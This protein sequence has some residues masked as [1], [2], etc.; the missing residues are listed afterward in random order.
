MMRR[1]IQPW[2]STRKLGG[3]WIIASSVTGRE[4]GRENGKEGRGIIAIVHCLG[5]RTSSLFL[6]V[7]LLLSLFSF[8]I[9]LYLYFFYTLMQ[10]YGF[11]ITHST[12]HAPVLVAP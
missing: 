5:H 7:F 9:F 4:K 8:F 12:N 6:S 1:S 10:I 3:V 2:K 11:K